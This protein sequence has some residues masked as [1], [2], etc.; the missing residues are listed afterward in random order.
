MNHVSSSSFFFLR[1]CWSSF[2]F[3][4]SVAPN[5]CKYVYVQWSSAPRWPCFLPLIRCLISVH[6]EIT[7][8]F[9]VMWNSQHLNT[10]L[11]SSD[12]HFIFYNNEMQLF[13]QSHS[14]S[15]KENN[16]FT[17]VKMHQEQIKFAFLIGLW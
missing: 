13:C 10:L 15:L 12:L 1:K 5:S 11:Q 9:I 17:M 8:P 6:V 4:E 3:Q 2:C 7:W 16:D 14:N